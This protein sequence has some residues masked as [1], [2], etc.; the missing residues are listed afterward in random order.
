MLPEPKLR[1]RFSLA[2]VIFVA[3]SRVYVFAPHWSALL[4]KLMLFPVFE[5]ATD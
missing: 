5:N 4:F 2:P 1:T 3:E